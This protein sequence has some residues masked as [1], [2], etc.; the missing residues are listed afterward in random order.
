VIAPFCFWT[1]QKPGGTINYVG[2][3]ARL[4][5]IWD[6][7]KNSELSAL[8]GKTMPHGVDPP[9]ILVIQSINER[10]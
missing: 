2:Y 8:S 7:E 4:L 10:I 3:L 5:M 9:K 1:T 6:V